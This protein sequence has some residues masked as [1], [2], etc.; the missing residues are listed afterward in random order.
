MKRLPY[1]VLRG[2][3]LIALSWS[4]GACVSSQILVGTPRQSIA[5]AQVQ[6]YREPPASFE[7][8]AYLETSSAHSWSFTDDA[9]TRVVIER[10][11]AQAAKLGANGLWLQAVSDQT[12]D[13]TGAGLG[14]ALVGT[15]GSVGIGYG[16]PRSKT[17]KIGR[18]TAIYVPPAPPVL[19]PTAPPVLP[20]T[21]QPAAPQ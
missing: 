21:A 18:A 12:V 7:E 8:L 16:V 19:P 2:T 9:R 5:V 6:V 14:A 17:D 11:K 1:K 13:A 20:P 10:L 3:A 4:L 15:H